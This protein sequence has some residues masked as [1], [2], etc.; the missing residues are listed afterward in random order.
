VSVS[1]DHVVRQAI[2]RRD[3]DSGLLWLRIVNR[4]R[5]PIQVFASGGAAG[6]ELVH[7]IVGPAKQ[8]SGWISGPEH[9][10]PINESTTVDI[11]PNTDL[12]FN[13]P[14]NHVGPSWYLRIAFDVVASK[15]HP[16][17]KSQGVVDFTWADIPKRE[18]N[19]WKRTSN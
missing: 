17:G 2:T 4:G 10:S 6:V 7:E 5:A 18:R 8:E 15:V 11:Q 9:Y 16:D 13:V 12:L 14:L 19:A 3:I 1:F